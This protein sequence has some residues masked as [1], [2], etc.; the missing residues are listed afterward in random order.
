MTSKTSTGLK[1]TLALVVLATLV[2]GP[3]PVEPAFAQAGQPIQSLESNVAGVVAD[4]LEAKREDGV[5]TI[6]VRFRN[7]SDKDVRLTAVRARQF[8]AYYVTAGTKKYLVLQ[9]E[10]VGPARAV[11][12]GLA[13]HPGRLVENTLRGDVGL[14]WVAI[15]R[16]TERRAATYH[17]PSP[18][19]SGQGFVARPRRFT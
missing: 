6:R 18:R 11:R 12:E 3:W 17:R 1:R 10:A 15:A 2:A 16:A 5:L 4:L 8:D 7:A 14:P 19:V 13:H 9:P